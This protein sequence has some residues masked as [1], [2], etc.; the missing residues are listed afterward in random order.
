MG[1]VLVNI[2]M[3]LTCVC[4]LLQGALPQCV[5]NARGITLAM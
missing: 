1:K 3:S 2:L 5:H 4:F